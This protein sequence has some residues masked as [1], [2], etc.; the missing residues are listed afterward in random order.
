MYE[1]ISAFATQKFCSFWKTISPWILFVLYEAE[2]DNKYRY[3]SLA[4]YTYF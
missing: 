1:L 4:N 3:L 2:L